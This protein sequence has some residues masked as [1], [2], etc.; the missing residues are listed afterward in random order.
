MNRAYQL[1]KPGPSYAMQDFLADWGPSGYYGPVKS[2]RIV[3]ASSLREASGV[4]VTVHVSPFSPFP[5]AEDFEKSRR[6]R[7][8]RVWVETKDKSFTFPP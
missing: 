4:I 1:W 5:V 8:V 6:T 2:Y 3:K 7:T